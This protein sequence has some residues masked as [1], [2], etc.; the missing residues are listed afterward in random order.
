VLRGVDVNR[1]SK[2]V[3]V[4]VEKIRNRLR[5]GKIK[6]VLSIVG[7]ICILIDFFEEFVEDSPYLKR[8]KLGHGLLLLTLA[9][10][11]QLIFELMEQLEYHNE[12]HEERSKFK[13]AL[14]FFQGNYYTDVDAAKAFDKAALAVFGPNAVTNF[15][16]QGSTTKQSKYRG[17][18]WDNADECWKVDSSLF[19][20]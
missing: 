14:E 5:L 1:S 2:H 19:L 13:E 10:L 9:N 20:H 7:G 6:T 3:D 16:I 4:N 15:G 17:V 8:L 11:L 18:V 12:I